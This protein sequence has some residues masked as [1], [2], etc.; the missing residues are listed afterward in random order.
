MASADQSPA[1]VLGPTGPDHGEAIPVTAF[2]EVGH[3]TTQVIEARWIALSAEDGDAAFRRLEPNPWLMGG[4]EPVLA[5]PFKGRPASVT[6]SLGS[7]SP[8]ALAMLTGDPLAFARD[9]LGYRPVKASPPPPLEPETVR[10][11]LARRAWFRK[12]IPPGMIEKL[13]SSVAPKEGKKG[14][15]RLPDLPMFKQEVDDDA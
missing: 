3:G 1:T 4:D 8:M 15:F 9:L 6:M 2:G 7:V 10:K 14:G 13:L 12:I 11:V 5:D